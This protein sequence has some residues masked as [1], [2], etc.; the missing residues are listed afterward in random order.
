MPRDGAGIGGKPSFQWRSDA[1]LTYPDKGSPK[2][3]SVCAAYLFR[4]VFP[5]PEFWA[6]YQWTPRAAVESQRKKKA[7]VT[8]SPYFEKLPQHDG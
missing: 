7:T 6:D 4:Y 2:R 5:I 3:R 1:A 8:G